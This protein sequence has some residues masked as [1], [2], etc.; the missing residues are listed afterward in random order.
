M[1]PR[2]CHGPTYYSDLLFIPWPSSVQSSEAIDRYRSNFLLPI[3][4]RIFLKNQ[5]IRVRIGLT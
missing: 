5:S 4:L 2:N 1:C 3:V